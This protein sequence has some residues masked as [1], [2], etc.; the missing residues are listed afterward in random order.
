[1]VAN[2]AVGFGPPLMN[3]VGLDDNSL[4]VELP[5]ELILVS[6]WLVHVVER[7]NEG[8]DI[9][10]REECDCVKWET[11]LKRNRELQKM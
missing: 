11:D 3:T 9:D 8:V 2:C 4:V 5:S 7:G 6:V 1:M 10:V